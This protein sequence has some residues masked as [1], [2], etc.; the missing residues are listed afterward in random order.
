MIKKL[1]KD[2]KYMQ[3]AEL[4]SQHLDYMVKAI[5]ACKDI[6]ALDE[7][8]MNIISKFIPMLIN[9]IDADLHR[10]SFRNLIS[11]VSSF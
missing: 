4:R 9:V 3:I 11:I 1:L 10:F 5:E 6:S 2:F 7:T 8:D